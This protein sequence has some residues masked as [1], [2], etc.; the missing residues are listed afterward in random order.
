M[1]AGNE[2]QRLKKSVK[3]YYE[4]P[5]YCQECGKVIEVKE[6]QRI[7]N[8]RRNKFCSVGCSSKHKSKQTRSKSTS[9]CE[10]CG[11]TIQLTKHKT[12]NYYN[13]RKYC[14][15]CV[16]KARALANT[17]INGQYDSTIP[18][19]TIGELKSSRKSYWSWRVEITKHS[20]NMYIRSGSPQKCLLCGY[21]KHF[22][23]CH[24]RDVALYS[25]DTKV[26]EVNSLSNLVALCRNCHWELDHNL[27][28]EEDKDKIMRA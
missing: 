27:L 22:D 7:C 23:V 25:D 17:K 11:G 13:P 15:D 4:N 3:Y 19:R 26:E 12:R 21:G 24:K 6:H 8:V 16:N 28:S 1:I 18:D 2:Q 5:N 9:L 10:M 20:R 14:D